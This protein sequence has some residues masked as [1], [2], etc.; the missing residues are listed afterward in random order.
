MIHSYVDSPLG[1]LLLTGDGEALTGLY[2]DQHGRLPTDLG[3]RA[4][5]EFAQ[6]RTQL[7]EYF[8]GERDTFDLPLNPRGTAFQQ[9]V[10]QALREIRYGT[11]MS[12]REVAEEIGNPKAVRAVGS[13]NSRNPISII[14][15]CHRV[16]GSD[17][18]LVGYAGGFSAKRWLLDHELATAGRS[19][20]LVATG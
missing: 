3:H 10:W 8:A 11:T 16:V 19:A 5:E 18:K 1:P 7:Q 13:A 12:Y 20:R 15:P 2:T 17:G 4:D 9:S 6:A 14:V